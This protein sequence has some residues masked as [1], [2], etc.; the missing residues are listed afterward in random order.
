MT[1]NF[2]KSSFYEQAAQN[3]AARHPDFK[4]STEYARA[5]RLWR[6]DRDEDRKMSDHA[7]YYADP[8][9]YTGPEVI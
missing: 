2:T 5:Q 9:S 1:T 4:F 6:A 7:N 8:E 3:W